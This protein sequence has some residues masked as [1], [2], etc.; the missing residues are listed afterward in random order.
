MNLNQ[1]RRNRFLRS[2]YRRIKGLQGK[3]NQ[4]GQDGNSQDT[5]SQE[6]FGQFFFGTDFYNDNMN[7]YWMGP[8]AQM[9]LQEDCLPGTFSFQLRALSP[10]HYQSFPF[11]ISIFANDHLI[12]KIL[13]DQDSLMQEVSLNL[14]KS[15]GNILLRLESDSFFV[16]AERG[17]SQ[18]TRKLTAIFS[19]PMVHAKAAEDAQAEY[20]EIPKST[21]D[22]SS[23]DIQDLA[24]QASHYRMALLKVK[25]QNAVD[26][27]WY[28]YDIM[29]NLV[30]HM[31]VLLH[32]DNR[33]LLNLAKNQPI[34]DI[35]AADGDL[36]FFLESIGVKEIDIIDHGPTNYNNLQGAKKLKQ[37][38]SS[39]VNIYDIDLNGAFE[40][41]R[42][43]YGLIIFLGI[44][45]HL[46]NPYYALK[47]LAQ[48]TEYCLI[49]TRIARYAM[50]RSIRYQKAPMAYLVDAQETNNDSTNYWIFSEEGL[51]RI[52]KRTGWKVLE[53]MT[54]GSSESDPVNPQ[55]DERAFCLVQSQVI[56]K[57]SQS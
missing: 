9:I 19:H 25:K 8:N 4:S 28:P 21:L 38:L 44:L 12:R 15:E 49:S 41:P 1:L 37:L 55:F 53:F 57:T 50:D 26:N 42:Q 32:G 7:W 34:A 54:V 20:I 27:F 45:Y 52:L 33:R 35:G 56:Q 11:G 16:P 51:R 5:A 24:M 18:D 23:L 17:E 48:S 43:N 3:T 14:G 47:K 46:E 6:I 13:I 40:L 29:A 36:S 22:A 30:S 39:N 10:D 31:G 2:I